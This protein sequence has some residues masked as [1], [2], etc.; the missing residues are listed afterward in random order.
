MTSLNT[1]DTGGFVPTLTDFADYNFII[2][3]F[4]WAKKMMERVMG[5]E[6]PQISSGTFASFRISFQVSGLIQ[7][8]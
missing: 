7:I 3:L 5:I 8:P 4:L 2:V 6:P 1:P